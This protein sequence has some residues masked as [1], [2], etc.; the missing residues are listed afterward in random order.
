MDVFVLVF[1]TIIILL[2]VNNLH[3]K[4]EKETR[5]KE[6]LQKIE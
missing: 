2:K 4:V 6:R 1:V 5:H 3:I